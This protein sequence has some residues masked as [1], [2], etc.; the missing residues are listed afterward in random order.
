MLDF[1]LETKLHFGFMFEVLAAIAGL[2]NLR[3][4]HLWAPEINLFIFYLLYIVIVE[5]YGYSHYEIWER[6]FIFSLQFWVPCRL[7]E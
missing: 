7:P 1:F 5:F 4:Q 6:I 3:S 2:L